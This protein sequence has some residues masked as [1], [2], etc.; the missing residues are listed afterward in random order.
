MYDQSRKSNDRCKPNKKRSKTL[1]LQSDLCDYSDTYVAVKE[2][3]TVTG[4]NN[5]D[6]I[7]SP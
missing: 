3:V 7:I 1:I 6:R 2:K 5:R 4:A